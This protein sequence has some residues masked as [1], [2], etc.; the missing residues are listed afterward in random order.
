MTR[1][2]MRG[3]PTLI[4]IDQEGMLRANYFGRPEDLQI[5]AEV[6]ALVNAPHTVSTN[7]SSAESAKGC[8]DEGCAV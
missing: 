3:T 7:T 8:T 5:G 2:Q 4:L 6:S 1:Y